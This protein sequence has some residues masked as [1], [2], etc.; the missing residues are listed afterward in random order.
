MTKLVPIVAIA[1]QLP[2]RL[3]VY[4]VSNKVPAP[5][6]KPTSPDEYVLSRA[7]GGVPPDV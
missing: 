6:T 4:P 7:T 2:Q 1:G 5:G 3:K